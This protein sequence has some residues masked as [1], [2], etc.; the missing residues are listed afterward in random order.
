MALQLFVFVVW[1]FFLFFLMLFFSSF[2]RS[3]EKEQQEGIMMRNKARNA[4]WATVLLLHNSKVNVVGLPDAKI[5]SE[6][7]YRESV[8]CVL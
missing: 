5:L 7:A 1:F 3:Q 2:P 8:F 6:I 4:I